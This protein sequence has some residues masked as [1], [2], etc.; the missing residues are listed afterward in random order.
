MSM[1][2]RVGEVVGQDGG[3]QPIRLGRKGATVKHDAHGKYQE[4]VMRGNVYFV[5]SANVS[6]TAYIGASNGT[7][8]LNIRNP[9]ASGKAI[10]IL[11]A[12]VGIYTVSTAAGVGD[13][14][15]YCYPNATLNTGTKTN[16]VNALT[17]LASGSSAYAYVNVALTNSTAYNFLMAIATYYFSNATPTGAVL[18]VNFI[19][20]GGIIVILPN[21]EVALGFSVVPT[22]TTVNF[23]VFWEEIPYP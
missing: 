12:S 23:A 20:L 22:S 10:V 19:D 14:A 9:N 21:N 15:F 8:L 1:Q 2:G 7:P 16:P 6:P 5:S 4:A 18:G 3:I 13:F 11:A 17:F